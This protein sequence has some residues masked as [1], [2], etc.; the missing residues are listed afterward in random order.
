[1]LFVTSNMYVMKSKVVYHDATS[2]IIWRSCFIDA[3]IWILQIRT[4]DYVLCTVMLYL[5]IYA[6]IF[7]F[8]HLIFISNLN[9]FQQYIIIVY[10]NIYKI[11]IFDIKFMQNFN[12]LK[13]YA[14]L[15]LKIL[16]S[17]IDKYK[18]FWNKTVVTKRM[19]WS[20]SI[21]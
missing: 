18:I 16:I 7:S 5:Y 11:Y 9:I 20:L 8:T 13:I 10:N 4:K 14:F 2:I 19:D 21:I 15:Y 1:M 17:I 12:S 6:A 3:N